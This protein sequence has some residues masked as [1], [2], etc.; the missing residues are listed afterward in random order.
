M[1]TISVCMIVKNEEKNLRNCLTPLKRIAD[2][3][4]V[5]DTGSTDRTKEIAREFTDKIYDFEWTCDFAAARNFAF[6]HA[7][8]D[9]IYSADA[10]EVI[11]PEN[12][13]VF[14]RLK[15]CLVPEVEIITMIYVN[16][17][18][19]NMAYNNLRER[20]PKLFKRLRTFTWIDE[21]HET[22]RLDPVVYD[23]DIEIL[24]KP[25]ENHSKRDFETFKKILEEKGD[26]SGRLW[27]MYAKELF[28][29]GDKDDFLFAKPYFEKRVT[30][31][32]EF[33]SLEAMCVVVRSWAEN[34]YFDEVSGFIDE[35]K[36]FKTTPAE[37]DYSLGRI[38]EKLGDNVTAQKYFDKSKHDESF[39]CVKYKAE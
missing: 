23:S 24:H 12:M 2:E 39:V 30:T 6:S 38:F 36:Y 16:P 8:C 20:R 35:L 32:E 37:I 21:I 7:T 3:I 18:D 26:M 4:I 19:I 1:Y 34:D 9:Y 17:A 31:S 13:R 33:S 11:D 22:I 27:S 15:M 29:N 25:H 14:E 28:F 5:V 10:D